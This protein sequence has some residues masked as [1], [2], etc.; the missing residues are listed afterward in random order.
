MTKINK[1]SRLDNIFKNSIFKNSTNSFFQN[2]LDKITIPNEFYLN[3]ISY[4]I[5]GESFTFKKNGSFFNVKNWL[6]CLTYFEFKNV[7]TIEGLFEDELNNDNITCFVEEAME[8]LSIF[9]YSIE[10]TDIRT[11]NDGNYFIISINF[12]SI[13]NKQIDFNFFNFMDLYS[14]T[15]K[16]KLSTLK[17]N[18]YRFNQNNKKIKNNEYLDHI[19]KPM[20]YIYKIIK[21]YDFN[22]LHQKNTI[23]YIIDLVR[24]NNW[25]VNDEIIDLISIN[26]KN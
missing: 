5:E 17:E 22:M 25:I 14:R 10:K 12:E 21:K 24:Q 1:K 6:V 19:E 15:S 13:E 16:E 18:I 20:F 4:N 9:K 2:F 7:L 11:K 8:S 26:Y 23:I 3:V